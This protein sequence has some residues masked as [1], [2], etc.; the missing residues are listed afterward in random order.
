MKSYEQIAAA[1]YHAYCKR[2]GPTDINGMPHATWTE[3]GDLSRQSW[4]AAAQ[5]ATAELALVH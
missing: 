4:I 1:M 5:Q 2:F 3:L